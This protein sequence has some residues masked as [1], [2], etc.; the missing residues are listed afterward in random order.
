VSLTITSNPDADESFN[1]APIALLD[2]EVPMEAGFAGPWGIRQRAGTLTP[3]SIADLDSDVLEAA[4]RQA[5]AVHCDPGSLAGRV[6]SLCRVVRQEWDGAAA[7]IWTKGDPGGAG[8]RRRPQALPG[9]GEQKARVLP[10]LLGRQSG[11]RG[12]GWDEASA[13]TGRAGLAS[14]RCRHHRSGIVD[15]GAI[16]SGC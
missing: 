14:Q 6:Q 7:R 9:I 5:P 12:T 2:R 16:T 3:G 1:S 8:V 13:P 15:P 11:D 4:F 10:A